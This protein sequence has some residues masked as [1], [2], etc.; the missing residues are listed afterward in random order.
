MILN[1]LEHGI[2]LPNALTCSFRCG[3]QVRIVGVEERRRRV[4]VTQK[5][6]EEREQDLVINSGQGFST[7]V[8]QPGAGARGLAGG[9]LAQALSRAGLQV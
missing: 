2:S 3:L 4:D 6:D 8:P 1:W 9:A 5:T 7:A